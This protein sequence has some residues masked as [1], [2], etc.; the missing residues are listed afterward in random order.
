M[1]VSFDIPIVLPYLPL[2]GS[3]LAL[4]M[5]LILCHCSRPINLLPGRSLAGSYIMPDWRKGWQVL[6]MKIVVNRE[7]GKEIND[8]IVSYRS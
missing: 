6:H 1:P 5:S 8:K 4:R 2:L 7:N 3:Q